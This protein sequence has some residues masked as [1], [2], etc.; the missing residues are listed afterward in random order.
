M[1]LLSNPRKWATRFYR[2][3]IPL[4]DV[5]NKNV[6]YQQV[7]DTTF[8]HAK[9]FDSRFG[10]YEFLNR[11]VLANEPIQYLEFGVWE[12]VTLRKWREIN[13]NPKSSF[14]GFDSFEGLPEDWNANHPKGAFHVN[15]KLPEIGDDRVRCVKG[16]FQ[17]SL[18]GFLKTFHSNGRLVVHIDCDLYSSALY[19]L[20]SLNDLI[21]PGSLVLFDEFRELEDEFSAFWDYS[22]AF[23]RKWEGLGYA[24]DFTH[25]ALLVKS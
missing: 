6:Q 2:R 8:A 5:L 21:V 22:R 10:L 19:C 13:T 3:R 11:E 18:P 7:L 9:H 4:F 12:G 20:A 23:Y 17:D 24:T 16:L 15:G 14:C 25:V 1:P